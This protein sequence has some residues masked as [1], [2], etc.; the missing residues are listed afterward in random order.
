MEEKKSTR[1]RKKIAA[2]E[3]K[4]R[5]DVWVRDKHLIPAT[6]ECMKIQSKYDK[7]Q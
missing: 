7:L 3:K 5:I 4:K 1:G 2:K 6:K